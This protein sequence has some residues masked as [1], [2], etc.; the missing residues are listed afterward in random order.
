MSMEVL[1]PACMYVCMY[2]HPVYA[3]DPSAE[4]SAARLT[5]ACCL[6]ASPRKSESQVQRPCLNVQDNVLGR[7]QTPTSGLHA[8]TQMHTPAHTCECTPNP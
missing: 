2:R 3:G 1:V 5:E 4:L 8:R 7:H 6:P